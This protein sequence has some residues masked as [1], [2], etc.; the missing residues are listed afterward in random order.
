MG[1]G[2]WVPASA[3]QSSSDNAAAIEWLLSERER[4]TQRLGMLGDNPEH[5]AL[6]RLLISWQRWCANEL[7]RLG[8]TEPDSN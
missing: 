2:P 1:S 8:F 5:A 3:Q 4:I 6:R 7:D